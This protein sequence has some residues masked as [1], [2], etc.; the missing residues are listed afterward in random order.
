[1]Q[2][3]RTGCVPIAHEPKPSCYWSRAAAA[4]AG[5]RQIE[6]VAPAVHGAT[7]SRRSFRS[8]HLLPRHLSRSRTVACKGRQTIIAAHVGRGYIERRFG[9]SCVSSLFRV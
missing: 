5:P 3:S 4:N 6:N 1:K 7:C 9:V 8:R 2:T